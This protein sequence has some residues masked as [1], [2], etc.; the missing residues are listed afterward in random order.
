MKYKLAI[1]LGILIF[2]TA[3]NISGESVSVVKTQYFSPSIRNPYSSEYSFLYSPSQHFQQ[4]EEIFDLAI[5]VKPGG[6]KP[7]VVRSDLLEEQPVPV[8]CQL[9]ALKVNPGIDI[10]RI[11]RIVAR[12]REKNPYVAGI[13]FHPSRA[14]IRSRGKL[15]STPIDTNLGYIVIVLKQIPSEEE[16]PDFVEVN[17]SAY[18]LYGSEYGEGIGRSEFYIPILSD[19]E[20]MQNYKDYSFFGGEFYLRVEDI[21]DNSAIVSIYRDADTRIFRQRL[22]KGK[23]YDNIYL[24]TYYGGRG[25]KIRL[26]DFEVPKTKAKIRVNDEVYEVYEGE[27]FS[28]NCYLKRAVY[29]GAGAGYVDIRCGREEAT[30][31][32]EL[33]KIKLTIDNEDETYKVG[34]KISTKEN[35]YLIHTGITPENIGKQAFIVLA[36]TTTPLT[37]EKLINI[38]KDITRKL[39]RISATSKGDYRKKAEKISSWYV[40]HL[41]IIFENEEKEILNHT[42]KFIEKE[43]RNKELGKETKEMYEKTLSTYDEILESFPNEEFNKRNNNEEK[44]KTYAQEILCNK[45]LLAKSLDQNIDARDFLAEMYDNYPDSI[46]DNKPVK[47][48]FTEEETYDTESSKKYFEKENLY[49]ELLSISEPSEDDASVKIVYN[50]IRGNLFREENTRQKEFV[51]KKSDTIIDLGDKQKTKITLKSFDEDSAIISVS[52]THL[53]LPTN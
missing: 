46:C 48:A 32:K 31:L 45:Y 39:K 49:V 26:L 4:Q 20:W 37:T 42:I 15:I 9:I 30:L 34:E 3:T 8:F 16:M 24:P 21:D 38:R 35:L 17:L 25:L 52:Y 2:L 51:L 19:S 29:Y 1:M 11:N 47:K 7:A 36:E 12:E 28:D 41:H 5:G 27:K 44:S 13:G 23:L 14:A 40:N 6:C 53:T 50:P 10:T 18:L 22:E 33:Q 43:L